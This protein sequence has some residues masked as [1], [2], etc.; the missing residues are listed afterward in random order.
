MLNGQ[1]RKYGH[2]RLADFALEEGVVHVNHGS[3]GAV[4]EAVSEAQARWR[5]ELERNPSRFFRTRYAKLLRAAAGHVAGLLGGE[6]PDWVFAENAT[7]AANT[8]IASLALAPGDEVLATDQIYGSVRKALLHHTARHGAALVQARIPVPVR[9][10]QDLVAAVVERLT[11]RTRVVVIDHVASQ[12][13]VVFPVA[14][15]A[16]ACRGA[17]VP[18]LVDG[19][20]APGMLS[21]DVPSLGVDWYCGNGHKWLGAPRGCGLLWTRREAQAALQP[22]VISHGHGLGYNAAFDW[23]GTRDP[24]AWLSVSAA[25]DYHRQCGGAALRQR[26]HALAVAAGW[27]LA[28]AFG[29]ELSAPA[30]LLGSMAT[31]RLP[32]ERVTEHQQTERLQIELEERFG[33]EASI[34]PLGRRP[35]LRVSAA[36]YNEIN[37]FLIAGRKAARLV[38]RAFDA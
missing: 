7:T 37:D 26:N 13:A 10:E 17:G 15:I 38:G 32:G 3:Y 16:E 29:T 14:R 33:V 34:V 12:S 23:T 24:S 30:H 19:A 36:I 20:H 28:T 9:A 4:P 22:L 6:G 8:V 31:I 27:Q 5:R 2:S 35:W 18:V 11:P 25:I 1:L 21:F